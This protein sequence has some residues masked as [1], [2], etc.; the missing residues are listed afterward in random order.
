[1][2][3]LTIITALN[4]QIFPAGYGLRIL[5]TVLLISVIL[6]LRRSERPSV[7]ALRKVELLV[8]AIPVTEM[9]ILQIFR[10]EYGMEI[11]DLVTLHSYRASIGMANCVVIA[12]YG[13]F[14]PS[15]W[16][17][18]AV[19]TTT[20]ALLPTITALIHISQYEVLQQGG[21]YNFVIPTFSL[22]M[23]AIATLGAHIVSSLRHD[24]E[25][26][27][28]YGQYHL[29]DEI[30]RG[31]MGIVYK[32]EHQML[33]R[34]AAIK[35]IRAESA[36]DTVAVERFEQEVQLSATLTHWNTVRIFDYGR[37][38][39][40]DFYYV[41]ELLQ[42]RT[43]DEILHIKDRLSLTETLEIVVQICDGLHEAHD[44]GMVHRDMKPANVFLADTGGRS[45]VVKI[46]DFGLA[47]ISAESESLT[48]DDQS[49]QSG[50][51]GTPAYMSPEQ[52]RGEPAGPP[53]DIYS[54]GCLIFQCLTGRYPFVGKTLRDVFDAHLQ[55]P[56][57]LDELVG[58]CADF[59]RLLTQ[60]LAK[61]TADRPSSVLA[62]KKECQR[63]LRRQSVTQTS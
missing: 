20:A 4:D 22:S 2:G 41:M 47:T 62:L 15:T 33:K 44:K 13:I 45:G 59:R 16:Q 21:T 5:A 27:R 60:C 32:A 17:R 34:P 14:I 10:T 40:G 55:Q 61:Q 35:L 30:G 19:I 23:A 24:V 29:S 43:L 53:S 56:I 9:V 38:D 1:M 25:A 3:V 37:T 7:A 31:S 42:G 36:A 51:C 6:F 46:L 8:I 12:M 63:I 26:A 50:L 18:T 57:D 48:P 54:L 58:D 39:H 52:I 11:D 28:Q 49:I